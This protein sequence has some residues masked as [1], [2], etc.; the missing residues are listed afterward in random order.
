MKKQGFT[1][2]EMVVIV[3]VLAMILVTVTNVLINSFKARNRSDLTDTLE[4]NGSYILKE[5]TKNFLGA[6]MAG[7]TCGGNSLTLI[8]KKDGNQ[9]IILCTDGANIASNSA[10]TVILTKGVTASNCSQFVSC[11]GAAGS[12]S[13][14]N[15]SFTLSAGATGSGIENTDSRSFQA[16]VAARN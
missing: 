12:V 7:V 14:I 6:D 3:S 5:I 11:E 10:N 9:T 15:V 1:L 4:Q 8:N 13:A 16:K 2:I